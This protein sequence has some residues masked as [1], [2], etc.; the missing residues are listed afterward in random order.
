MMRQVFDVSGK[1]LVLYQYLAGLIFLV[2]FQL[3]IDPY[4]S[5][6][7]AYCGIN[8]RM[9]WRGVKSLAHELEKGR[10]TCRFLLCCTQD[11]SSGF[12]PV[13]LIQICKFTLVL[14]VTLSERLVYAVLFV[15]SVLIYYNLKGGD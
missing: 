11:G 13:I 15:L 5:R 4:H 6:M 14:H 3:N 9:L 7:V 10:W 8:I 2:R 1:H 12:D